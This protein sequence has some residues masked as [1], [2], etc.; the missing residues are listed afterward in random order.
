[1]APECHSR[2]QHLG[3][4]LLGAGRSLVLEDDLLKDALRFAELLRLAISHPKSISDWY[5]RTSDVCRVDADCLV[6]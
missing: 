5:C 1:L 6:R 3:Q 4:L 2:K